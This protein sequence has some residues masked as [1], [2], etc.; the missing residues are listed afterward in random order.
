MSG[1]AQIC[2]E[3]EHKLKVLIDNQIVDFRCEF[4]WDSLNLVVLLEIMAKNLR[5]RSRLIC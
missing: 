5:L 1:Q 3:G 2:S 4:N